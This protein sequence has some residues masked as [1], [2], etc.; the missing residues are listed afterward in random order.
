[1]SVVIDMPGH[2]SPARS[3]G[4]GA[5]WAV[6]ALASLLLAAES[7]SGQ[8]SNAA[9][10]NTSA[11]A[12]QEVKNGRV[13]A[14][15]NGGFH[16]IYTTYGSSLSLRYRRYNGSLGQPVTIQNA[17][18]F[19]AQI[20]EALNGDIHIIWENWVDLGEGE[21]PY[22]GWSR[23]TNGGV[24]FS[25]PQ[26][27]SPGDAKAPILSA[28]GTGTGGGMLMSFWK[29][30]TGRFYYRLFD[31]ST[32]L[33]EAEIAGSFCDNQYQLGGIDRSPVDGAVWRCISR[34]LNNVY[35][36][37]I[38]RFDGVAW[39]PEI[40]LSDST[41]FSDPL[42]A[43]SQTGQVMALWRDGNVYSSVLYTPGSG[44]GARTIVAPN[45]DWGTSLSSIATTGNFCTLFPADSR[46]SS[47]TW[48]GQW[49]AAIS[50]CNGLANGFYVGPDVSS[51]PDG[52]LYAAFENWNTGKPQQYY[53][54]HPPPPAGP[55][56]TLAGTVRDQYG[57]PLPGA[58]V[59][60]I[61]V[62]GTAS[63]SDGSFSLELVV[64]THT[65]HV[66][67]NN[68]LPQQ[69]HDI[70]ITAGQTT[71]LN[72]TLTATA[73]GPLAVLGAR[74]E[75]QQNILNWTAPNDGNLSGIVI[76]YRLDQTPAGPA[77]G[78]LAADLAVSPGASGS[79]VHANLTNGTPYYYAA[80][81]YFQDASRHY[82]AGRFAQATP[83]MR[84]DRDKDGDV[85][86]EDFGWFQLCYSGSTVPQTAPAC[87][88]ARID[89]DEDVDAGD[90][91]I[92]QGCMSGANV[93]A[94]PACT[95]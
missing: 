88:D 22:V 20:R 42:L 45:A 54:I 50:A 72:A 90:F 47:R 7:S 71:A 73:P 12:T 17:L 34:K 93:P 51:G 66:S 9:L 15:R 48:A 60:V 84:I 89:G 74:G 56:G 53:A 64:G 57:V 95:N 6:T 59:S 13:A 37:G 33:P 58:A 70:S 43:V 85:D 62:D 3:M 77:D 55:K 83:A 23:S 40:L 29:P 36:I 28:R 94:D 1:M 61:G 82:S 16:A 49:S 21:K 5:R 30:A 91:A 14:S 11:E 75:S 63:V 26:L 39:G 44:A 31:G 32:W 65:V 86:Q 52:T 24:S 67:K 79:F 10:L 69:Y 8:W 19:G 76:R 27:I 4:V 46:V 92:F 25:P 81:S 2:T 87:T 68:Y 41:F 80:F 18:V 38:R 78:Q 35:W